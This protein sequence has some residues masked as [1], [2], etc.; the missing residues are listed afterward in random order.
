[1]SAIPQGRHRTRARVGTALVVAGLV[2]VAACSSSSKSSSS[3]GATATTAA[4]TATTAGSTA[5]TA[6]AAPATPQTI[7]VTEIGP[8]TGPFASSSSAV[9]KVFQY[10]FD[11]VNAGTG[12]ISAPGFTFKL[13]VAD[14]GNVPSKALDLARTALSNGSHILNL[15]GHAEVDAVSPLTNSGQLL[16]TDEDPP[17]VSASGSTYPYTF[18]YFSNDNLGIQAQLKLAAT[19]GLKKMAILAGAGDQY[20]GYVDDVNKYIGADDPGASVVLTQRFDPNTSDF[21]SIVTKVQQAG[22]DSVWFFATGPTVQ[23]YYQAMIAA[24]NND[25]IFN[26]FGSLTC[27]GCFTLAPKFLS[28]V[29]LADEEPGTL[30]AASGAPAIPAYGTA[31]Q[32]LWTH[33]NATSIT[34]KSTLSAY[35]EDIAY[36]IVWSVKMAGGDNPAKLKAVYEATAASGGVSFISPQIKYAWSPTDHDGF[37]AADVVP[38]TFSFNVKWPFFFPQAS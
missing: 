4:A 36:G 17:D 28:H 26:A 19:K 23:D 8:F 32:T 11:Q 9:Q 21:S 29:Y 33:Y 31:T 12:L 3:S 37:P 38:V 18:D 16:G 2:S 7:T 14:D 34:D 25:P 24:N 15:L 20:Q 35:L 27:S 22:A 30:E 10:V 5:T 6:A 1:M 13:S